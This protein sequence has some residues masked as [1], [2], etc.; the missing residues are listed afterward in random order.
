MLKVSMNSGGVSL[1]FYFCFGDEATVSPSPG[2]LAHAKLYMFTTRYLIDPLREQ[3][4]KSLHRDLR[5]FSLNGQ[6]MAHILDLLEYTYEPTGKQD[7][8][9]SYS[10][11]MLVIDYISCEA[12]ILV[13]NTRVPAYAG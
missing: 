7:P 10:L 3:C 4:W 6:N 12:R 2:L 13:E 8:D 1:N 11:R 5:N 9:G